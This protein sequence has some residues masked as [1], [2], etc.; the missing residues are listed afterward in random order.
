[1]ASLDHE[2]RLQHQG[3]MSCKERQDVSEELREG[4]VIVRGQS[5]WGQGWGLAYVVGALAMLSPGR[6]E[7]KAPVS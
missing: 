1:M 4:R 3:V 5:G 7:V 2:V 6:S